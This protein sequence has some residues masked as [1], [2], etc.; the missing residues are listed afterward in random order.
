MKDVMKKPRNR[1]FFQESLFK[2]VRASSVCHRSARI[3]PL[4]RRSKT[5]ERKRPAESG[6]RQP[7]HKSNS[8][9]GF[10]TFSRET[11]ALPERAWPSVN[12]GLDLSTNR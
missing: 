12:R 4:A 6:A 3:H 9:S 5:A 1:V 2:G 7:G 11:E 8:E 10:E